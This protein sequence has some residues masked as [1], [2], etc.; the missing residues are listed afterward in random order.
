MFT[1]FRLNITQ[2]VIT[3]IITIGRSSYGYTTIAFY[4]DASIFLP[5]LRY[6]I[7]LETDITGVICVNYSYRIYEK[8]A[9]LKRLFH[10][11][12]SKRFT[13]DP[14]PTIS[15]H[16]AFFLFTL[17]CGVSFHS[18]NNNYYWRAMVSQSVCK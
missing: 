8:K 10:E 15:N 3:S 2:N 11:K 4:F 17:F 14:K 18:R 9:S 5:H 6:S 13:Q 1:S 16:C 12:Y 7:L